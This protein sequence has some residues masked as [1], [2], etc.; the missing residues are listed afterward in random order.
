M[1]HRAKN[2]FEQAI[3]DYSQAIRIDPKNSLALNNRAWLWAVCPD[4]KFRD[5]ARAVESAT[6]ACELTNWKS[7]NNVDTLAAACA[8]A[9]DFDSAIRWQEKAQPLFPDD[10][11]RARGKERLNLYKL[12]KPFRER[13]APELKRP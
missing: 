9:G 2:E 1:T 8:E 13:E 10:E 11:T 5:G 6:R 12:G 3:E 7:A 4:A